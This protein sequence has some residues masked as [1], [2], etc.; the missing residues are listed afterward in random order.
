MLNPSLHVCLTTAKSPG[1]LFATSTHSSERLI[2]LLSPVQ[3]PPLVHLSSVLLFASRLLAI[4]LA[5]LYMRQHAVQVSFQS[6][7][8]FPI[9]SQSFSKSLVQEWR[10][11][12]FDTDIAYIRLFHTF[13][14]DTTTVNRQTQTTPKWRAEST[15]QTQHC[16]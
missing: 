8:I 4:R 9:C 7:W 13:H 14:A 11:I 12:D 15:G 16:T 10:Q 6:P 3:R 2:N 5:H 1:A